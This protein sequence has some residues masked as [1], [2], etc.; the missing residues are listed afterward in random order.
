M[1]TQDVTVRVP[2]DRLGEFYEMFGRW[3]QGNSD[4]GSVEEEVEQSPFAEATPAQVA[5]WWTKLKPAAQRIFTFLA[6]HP[7][8]RFSGTEL[9]EAARIVKG[10]AAVAGTLSWPGKHAYRMGLGFPLEW[11]TEEQKY[12]MSTPVAKLLVV[13]AKG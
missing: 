13:V 7:G 5:E 9:A 8:Q 1:E 2:T 10:P 6:T 12:W 11:E 3:L 4:A